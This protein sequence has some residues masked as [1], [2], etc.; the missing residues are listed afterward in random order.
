MLFPLALLFLSFL[1]TPSLF[2]KHFSKLQDLYDKVKSYRTVIGVGY[3]VYGIF[4]LLNIILKQ[5]FTTLRLSAIICMILLGFLM[6]FQWIAQNVVGN[7]AEA[8][9]KIK[10]WHLKILPY[11]GTIAIVALCLSV[12]FL[13]FR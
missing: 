8:K 7:S 13:I 10:E 6:G 9:E 4:N 2:I 12:Y 1:A 3:L 11:E 5:G